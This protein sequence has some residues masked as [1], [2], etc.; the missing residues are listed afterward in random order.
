[1]SLSP[2]EPPATELPHFERPL[3]FFDQGRFRQAL[4]EG[5]I[6]PVF[7]DALNA[8]NTQFDHRFKEGEGIRN[9]VYERALFLDCILH[10]AW[11]QFEWED[12]ISMVAVGGYGRGELHPYSDID[13]LI[14]LQ[15][16]NTHREGDSIECFLTLLWDIGLEIGHSVRTIAQCAEIAEQDITVATNLLECRTLVGPEGL[17]RQLLDAT[18]PEKM[19]PPDAFFKAKWDEQIARH[20]KHH[21]TEYNLE[22]NVK[23]APGGLRDIQV[24]CWVAK[25][26]FGVRTLKELDGKG[27]FTEEEFGILLSG[28]EYLWKVRYGLHMIAGRAEERLLFDHQRELALLFGHEDSDSRLAVEHFMKRYYRLVLA[29]RE[30]NDVMLQ[31]LDEAILQ[32]G[33]SHSVTPINERFQLRDNY[34]E[35]THTTV[36]SETPSALLEVFVLMGKNPGIQGVRASTIRLIRENRDLIDEDFRKQDENKALFL[37]FMR[38]PYKLVSLLRSMKRYRV[39]GRYLPAFGKITGQMQHDLFHIYTVDAHTLLLIRHMRRFL[40]S[41]LEEKFPIATRIMKRIEKP[42]LLYITGLF[43]DIAKGRG[44]DHSTLG[45]VD[46]EEFCTQHGLSTRETR[47]ICWLV[48]KHLVMSAVSQKQDLSD[49]E[50]IHRFASIVGDR[51]RLDYLYVLTVADINAT[52]PDLWTSWRASLMRQL[53]EETKRAFRRGLENPVDPT[54]LIE[55]TQQTAMRILAESGI[56][57][58]HARSVWGSVGDGYFLREDATDIAW[59]TQ[60][61]IEA[62]NDDLLISIRETSKR[63]HEGATEIFIS[64]PDRKNIFAAVASTLDQLN[65][66]IWDARIYNSDSGYTIDTFYVLDENGESIGNDKVRL[67]RIRR[68]LRKVLSKE[69]YTPEIINRRTPRQLKNFS[70]PTRVNI[71]EDSTHGFTI[72]EVFSPD[73]PGLLARIG[74]VFLQFDVQLLNAK[75]ATLGERVEDIFFICDNNGD[76]IT[77]PELCQA[78]EEELCRQLDEQAESNHITF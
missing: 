38:S 72:L 22:P 13:L 3:F 67:E 43:H 36:F 26:F 4:G 17:R 66:N 40:N 31:F 10:Y 35:V 61:I 71:I 27:F 25:R 5:N 34:I 53:Y 55:E 30:L 21:N 62:N 42:E 48:E 6:I 74:R 70:M 56:S 28:E 7:K 37:A 73:R 52:N 63:E 59:H 41:E 19:W 9:L 29:L 23:N 60:S 24:I 32:R 39:L 68:T 65:L 8:A 2:I 57:R 20:R 76:T 1:M 18:A 50:V 16:D 33:T 54:E 77:D 45:A 46:A 49:P 44:G 47:L 51:S 75:I 15:D 64:T 14:L 58:E 12:S 11:H 78:L 69:D